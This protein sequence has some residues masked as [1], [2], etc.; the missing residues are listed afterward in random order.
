VG[1][2]YWAAA[3]AAR[4]AVI[5]HEDLIVGEVKNIKGGKALSYIRRSDVTITEPRH[6]SLPKTPLSQ[7]RHLFIGTIH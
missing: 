5:K 7:I 2:K 1:G 4:E 3:V 6:A